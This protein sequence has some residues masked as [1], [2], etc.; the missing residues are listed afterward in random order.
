V[1]VH[2]KGNAI[3]LPLDRDVEVKVLEVQLSHSS[4]K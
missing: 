4:G 1:A 2:E 3:A